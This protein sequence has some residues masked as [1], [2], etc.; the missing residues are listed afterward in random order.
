[1]EISENIPKFNRVSTIFKRAKIILFPREFD[2][3]D[4]TLMNILFINAKKKWGGIV[5]L[6]YRLAINFER[7][8][9][10]TWIISNKKS[11]FTE[12]APENINLIPR[13]FGMDYNPL[14]ILH[15]ILFI[16]KH[17]INIIITNITKEI[18]AGGIAA[19][20]CNIPNIRMIGN[21]RDF[22]KHHFLNRLL[23]DKNV[24]PC[25]KVKELTIENYPYMKEENLEVIHNGYTLQTV[26]TKKSKA[27]RKR[28]KIPDNAFVIGVTGRLV[29]DKGIQI[30]I[31]A[32]EKISAKYR[33][34]VLVITGSGSYKRELEILT[35]KLKLEAKVIFSGFVPNSHILIT[36]SIYDIAV[37]PSFY[38]A[39]PVVLLEYLSLGKAVISTDV[40]GVPELIRN[41]GN[42]FLIK[43]N[44]VNQLAEKIEELIS[45]N[46][47][48]EK[49]QKNAI[50]TIET[51]FSEDKMVSNFLKVFTDKQ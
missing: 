41:N 9:F 12:N 37:M 38:E 48:R 31:K 28:L 42:G 32:F 50:H 14:L 16:K 21:E 20:I 43:P 24:L 18:I 34:A 11:A 39:F 49:F 40:G 5:S 19:K 22:E 8:N 47:L 26:P 10:Q 36:N 13:T 6:I 44:S 29:K 33:N 45:N 30:L 7:R 2:K 17:K 23:V 51:G 25:Q 27:E 35:G 46:A 4:R 3:K 1:L 15:L